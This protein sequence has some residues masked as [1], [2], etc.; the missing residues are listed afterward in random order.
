MD[1]SIKKWGN[2]QGIR[3]PKEYLKTLGI[4]SETPLSIEIAGNTIVIHKKYSH[5]TLEE[6]VSESGMPLIFSEETDWG[7]PQGSEVW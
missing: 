2:S 1:A 7:K 4:T 3:I 6:R 5:K